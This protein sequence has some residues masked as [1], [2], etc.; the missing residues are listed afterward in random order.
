[1]GRAAG[2]GAEGRGGLDRPGTISI[3]VIKGITLSL[4]VCDA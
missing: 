3:V 2:I 4:M 1:M